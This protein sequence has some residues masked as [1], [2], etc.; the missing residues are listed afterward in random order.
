MIDLADPPPF[1]AL[2]NVRAP[3]CLVPDLDAPAD[4][5]GLLRLDIAIA[6]GAIGAVAP[7]GA[8]DAAVPGPDLGGALVLPGLVDIHTHLDKGFIW[9]RAQNPDGRFES[10]IAAVSADRDVH[11]DADDLARRMTFGLR[12][13][14][15][16]GTVALRTHLDSIGPKTAIAWE[17]F[18]ELRNTWADRI[19]LQ[20]VSLTPIDMV[21]NEAAFAPALEAV[22]T[23]GGVL[24]ATCRL[25]KNLDAGLARLFDAADRFGADLDFH[26]DETHDTDARA[27]RRIAEVADE[28]RFEGRI[29]VGHCC[30]LANQTADEIDRTLDIMARS[31]IGVVSLPMCNLYLQDRVAGRTPR[32]RG[33]TLLHEMRARG[34]PVM[35]ASDNARD[36]FYAY[37]DLDLVEVYRESSRIA[38]LDHPFGDWPRIV[39]EAPARHMGLRSLAAIR[40]AGPA[41]LLLFKARSLNELMARPLAG[42][43]VLRAGRAIDAAVPDYAELDDL[44]P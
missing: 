13:A 15:A 16:H 23:H 41:D 27:L 43:I 22:R 21:A 31:R 30:A 24:G 19:A 1:F 29:L 10:A 39:C 6:H 17:V 5:E 18:A 34:I 28:R 40:M 4:P 20:A 32:W 25:P 14:Y 7:A 42:R 9:P 35:V 38:H 2:R 8:L 11:W 12:C 33:I 44:W 3:A 37:G 36:P 26:V